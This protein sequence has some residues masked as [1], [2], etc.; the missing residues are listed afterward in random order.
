M[1]NPFLLY[2]TTAWGQFDSLVAL[3]TLAALVLLNKQHTVISS[4]LLALA[5]SLKPTPVP[6]L[7][8]VMVY[9]W[10]SPWQRLARYIVSFTL[11][12]LIFCVLPFLI[13]QWDASPI[14]RGWN[15]QF[16]VSG[17]MSLT[18]L[19][20][21][22]DNTYLLPGNWWLL[23]FV[24]L[25]AILIGTMFMQKGNQGLARLAQEQPGNDPD[26]LPHPYLAFRAKPHLDPAH[27]IDPCPRG[28]AA[29]THVIRGLDS[30]INIHHFQ[31]LSAT[32]LVSD[33]A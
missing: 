16:S 30:S 14:F 5:I 20:E 6:V 32:A 29:Q 9:L 25:P 2:F 21:L 27:G 24:W 17:G 1:F 8:V 19:Y 18:T 22:L 4:I 12:M 7:L 15:A 23:G 3:L 26:L 31:Y 13:F 10:G 11:S 28:G 33:P